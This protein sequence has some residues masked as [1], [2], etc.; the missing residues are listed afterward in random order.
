MIAWLMSR[1]RRTFLATDDCGAARS[2]SHERR[3]GYGLRSRRRG[4]RAGGFNP[5]RAAGCDRDQCNTAR[6]LCGATRRAASA[7]DSRPWWADINVFWQQRE[8]CRSRCRCV[9]AGDPNTFISSPTRQSGPRSAPRRVGLGHTRVVEPAVSVPC[10]I[11]DQRLYE[12]CRAARL[13]RRSPASRAT[14]PQP[15]SAR[16]ERAL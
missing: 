5:S 7:R 14:I 2:P 8:T 10:W 16:A 3:E 13:A 15:P 1:R 4:Y 9:S 6:R 11:G 12:T